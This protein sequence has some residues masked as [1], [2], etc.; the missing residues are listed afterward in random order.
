MKTFSLVT[1]AAAFVAAPVNLHADEK[2]SLQTSAYRNSI[3]EDEVRNQTEKVKTDLLRLMEDLQQN[4]LSGQEFAEAENVIGQLGSLSEKDLAPLVAALREASSSGD[5]EA[6]SKMTGASKE[7][8]EVQVAL[9]G[10]A[11][12]LILHQ[13]QASM[14]QRLRQLALKQAANTRRTDEVARAGREAANLPEQLQ[15]VFTL[16]VEEQNAIKKEVAQALDVLKK[17]VDARPAA[18]RPG[19]A[20]ALSE[21]INLKMGPLADTAASDTAAGQFANAMKLQ[22]QVRAGLE[23]MLLKLAA[24]QPLEERVRET[25]AKANELAAQQKQ[26][27]EASKKADPAARRDIEE[28]QN[29][30]TDQVA[31]L[32]KEMQDFN[33]RAAQQT[34]KAEQAARQADEKLKAD[35]ERKTDSK[36]EIAQAQENAARELGKVDDELKEQL[37]RLARAGENPKTP[38]EAL[39]ALA[40]AEQE[41]AQAQAQQAVASHNPQA[42]NREEL[43]KKLE[44]LQQEILPLNQQAG[45]EVGAAAAQPLTPEAQQALAQAQQS[46]REQMQAMSQ[47]AQQQAA[48]QAL[49]N[50]INTAQAQSA[51]AGQDMKNS[52]GDQTQAVK[53]MEAA[54]Q[55]LAQVNASAL[56]PDAKNALEQA[57]QAL[58]QAKLQAAQMKKD[59]AQAANQQAQKNMEQAKTALNEAMQKAMEQL[60]GQQLM[61]RQNQ[62]GQG[63]QSEMNQ[64]GEMYQGFLQGTGADA[65]QAQVGGSGLEVKEREAIAALQKEKTP[66]EYHGMVQQYL[67]NLA[68]GQTP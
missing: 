12:R 7:Q 13:L 22:S 51:Q 46:L 54:Q 10:M 29:K 49:E 17:V 9:K 5:A 28:A 60:G 44:E 32:K 64:K 38:A 48:M 68:D 1:L 52:T 16:N 63:R 36:N 34:E 62:Q 40:K 31:A 21:G 30:L 47:L 27:A 11:D 65:G 3:A 15:P 24:T 67:R 66:P 50:Q 23:A 45:K 55:T 8:K 61:A 57:G 14:V 19:F 43:K 33:A 41:V 39:Q 6:L 25:A 58:D 26:L 59:Q 18:E 4:N 35:R 53:N 56:P 20:E 37:E 42:V 2:T